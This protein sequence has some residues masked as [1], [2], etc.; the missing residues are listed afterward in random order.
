MSQAALPGMQLPPPPTSEGSLVSFLKTSWNWSIPPW[1]QTAFI[2]M[3][4]CVG[5]KGPAVGAREQRE[6]RELGLPDLGR[7]LHGRRGLGMTQEEEF[8]LNGGRKVVQKEEPE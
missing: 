4:G 7:N 2:Y 1:T 6:E 5:H 3:L 8:D